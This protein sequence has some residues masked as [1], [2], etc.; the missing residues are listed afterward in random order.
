MIP[1]SSPLCRASR[2]A[3]MQGKQMCSGAL[4]HENSKVNP[5]TFEPPK[6]LWSEQKDKYQDC[7]RYK[8]VV[9]V[10]RKKNG[11][12]TSD[13]PRRDEFSNTI[14][15]EQLREILKVGPPHTQRARRLPPDSLAPIPGQSRIVGPRTLCHFRCAIL[16]LPQPDFSRFK[17]IP[18]TFPPCGL[19][20]EESRSLFGGRVRC[21][22]GRVG[23]SASPGR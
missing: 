21:A 16:L 15:T 2:D 22:C 20:C 18:A 9:P 14:R 8:D 10:E 19:T 13:F 3:R 5:G 7:I 17:P 12:G 1:D 4:K 6:L 11:F 23:D